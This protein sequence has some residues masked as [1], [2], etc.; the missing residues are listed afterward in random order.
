[1]NR[2]EISR[3]GGNALFKKYGSQYMSDL[4]RKGA[5]EFWRKYRLVPTET[6]R[7]AIVDRESGKFIAFTLPSNH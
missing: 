7:F 2:K 3:L 1:M 4:G 5:T 6:Y